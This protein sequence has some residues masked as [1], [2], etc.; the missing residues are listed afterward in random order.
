MRSG[1]NEHH[2]EGDSEPDRNR[3]SNER[4]D[5]QDRRHGGSL[6]GDIA[7]LGGQA[8]WPLCI[9][10]APLEPTARRTKGTRAT[11]VRNWKLNECS[12]GGFLMLDPVGQGVICG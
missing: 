2:D 9:M 7:P 6:A 10:P 4:G 3:L 1:L 8:V 5:L 12:E 11:P